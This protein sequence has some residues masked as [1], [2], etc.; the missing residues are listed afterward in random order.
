MPRSVL[1]YHDP[2]LLAGSFGD[3][4]LATGILTL[5]ALV[6]AAAST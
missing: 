4:E 2:A 3:T 6:A 1:A 5:P